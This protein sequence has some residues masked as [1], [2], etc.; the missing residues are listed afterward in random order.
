MLLDLKKKIIIKDD[1]TT[2]EKVLNKFSKVR[3]KNHI[4]LN[5]NGKWQIYKP[6]T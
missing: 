2:L 3:I 6:P 5:N 1:Y 4:N